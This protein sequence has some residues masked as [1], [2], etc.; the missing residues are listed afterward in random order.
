M[1]LAPPKGEIASSIEINYRPWSVNTQQ[2]FNGMT[3]SDCYALD[4]LS[5]LAALPL[6]HN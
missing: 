2:S 1:W 6:F 4:V 5:S 3:V